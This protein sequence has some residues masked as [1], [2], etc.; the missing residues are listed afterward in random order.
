ME[1][2]YVLKTLEICEKYN[3]PH[4]S[5]CSSNKTNP[6]SWF[7]LWRVK[8]ETEEELKKRKIIK[9]ISVFHCGILLER[10]NDSRFGERLAGYIPFMEKISVKQVAKAMLITDLNFNSKFKFNNDVNLKN[11]EIYEV[12]ENNQMISLVKNN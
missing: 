10:D 12:I 8:G 2:T 11:D 3:I 4:F 9:K 5:F 1:K 7:L 6:N